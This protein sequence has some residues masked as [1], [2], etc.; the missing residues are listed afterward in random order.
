MLS[1]PRRGSAQARLKR[2]Q[3]P[4][5]DAENLVSSV[6]VRV[7]DVEQVE[8]LPPTLPS[9]GCPLEG[10]GNVGQIGV[11]VGATSFALASRGQVSV[12]LAEHAAE[13]R[14]L[15]Q[16][17]IGDVIEIGRRLTECRKITGHGNWLPW[18]NRE[19]GW[20]HSAALNFMRAF[21]L[22]KSKSANFTNLNLPISALYLLAAPSTPAAARDE[23]LERAGAG[24]DIKVADVK[25]VIG[26]AKQSR[27]LK[28][29]NSAAVPKAMA[30]ATHLDFIAAWMG[31]A[32]TERTK[33]IDRIGLLPL[34]NAM[35]DAGGHC[36]KSMLPS[37]SSNRPLRRK[38]RRG[39]MMM[40]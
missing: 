35:P 39:P 36:L 29:A 16:R 25:K 5:G 18:L 7:A 30:R 1:R 24:E 40:T 38:Q 34:L 6:P 19:L 26:A 37:V 13:I 33:A 21:Q 22:A 10:C 23:I 17:V 27:P 4:E 31:A 3:R 8:P 12:S 20:S 9:A 2:R 11:G 14:R 15:G 32:P 28:T